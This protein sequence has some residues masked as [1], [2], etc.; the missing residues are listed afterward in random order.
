MASQTASV[1]D[2]DRASA[3]KRFRKLVEQAIRQLPTARINAASC[4]LMAQLAVDEDSICEY[5]DELARDLREE[6][7]VKVTT[8]NK[9]NPRADLH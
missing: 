7:R 2:G 4:A 8:V 1:F 6:R 3:E 9:R 5:A